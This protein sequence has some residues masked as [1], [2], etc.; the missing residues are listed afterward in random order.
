MDFKSAAGTKK[1][2]KTL[3][4]DG[5]G[6]KQ[7]VHFKGLN[8]IAEIQQCHCEGLTVKQ[9]RAVNEG[10]H[11]SPQLQTGAPI[12]DAWEE[13]IKRHRQQGPGSDTNVPRYSRKG[14]K[15]SACIQR[16]I[17]L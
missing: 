9:K 14:I 8:G 13:Q 1:H 4:L 10:E 2:S 17:R 12:K 16:E 6:E 11:H 15:G 3:R 7:L 5:G